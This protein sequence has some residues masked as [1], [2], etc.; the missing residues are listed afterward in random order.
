MCKSRIPLANPV[1]IRTFPCKKLEINKQNQRTLAAG[2]F[3]DPMNHEHRFNE[4]AISHGVGQH[5]RKVGQ[6]KGP[7]EL[8]AQVRLRHDDTCFFHAVSV[9][10]IYSS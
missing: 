10:S 6:G 2:P 7:Q 3:P 9:Y 4:R 5:F 8:M 1:L